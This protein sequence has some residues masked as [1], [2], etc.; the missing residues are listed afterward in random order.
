[1]NTN[2]NTATTNTKKFK[3]IKCNKNL[4]SRQSKWR[5]ENTCKYSNTLENRIIQ[6]ENIIV[7]ST[8]SHLKHLNM[9]IHNIISTYDIVK[10]NFFNKTIINNENHF[11]NLI[12][13]NIDIYFSISNLLN[14]PD[15]NVKS[16][17][18]YL[19][20]LRGLAIKNPKYEEHINKLILQNNSTTQTNQLPDN[21]TNYESDS[22]SV[23]SLYSM[24][25]D[26]SDF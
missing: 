20:K 25:S 23:H 15:T 2:T 14:H 8:N 1:M 4:S 16:N 5:H 26:I 18:K 12:N 17:L 19:N 21:D 9:L 6:L 7:P 11:N 24:Y 3:C 13:N 10:N 22:D